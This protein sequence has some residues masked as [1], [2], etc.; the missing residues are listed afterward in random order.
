V[1][2]DIVLPALLIFVDPFEG[3]VCRVDN[4]DA[5]GTAGSQDRGDPA[6]PVR[7]KK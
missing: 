5:A 6:M 2:Y 3:L 7:S 1:V 4:W